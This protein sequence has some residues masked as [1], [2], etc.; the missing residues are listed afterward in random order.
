[1]RARWLAVVVFWFVRRFVR[2]EPDYLI[3]GA[4]NP[5]MRRWWLLP[6]NRFFNVYLHHIVRDDDD[7]ALHDHPWW[8][9]SLMLAGA[10]L[11]H[12]RRPSFTGWHDTQR[13]R[14]LSQ[15]A[16]T[17]RSARFAH[18]LSVMSG[19]GAWT[20]FITGPRIREWGFHCPQGWKHWKDFTGYRF[21]GDS[22]VVGPGCE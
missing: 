9:F 19:G 22:S 7:R 11:E 1:M 5:Y 13:L 14:R 21:S 15:G 3:G 4:E 17:F 18:R 8:S 6:R 10:L 2:R 16:M 20:L 12:Y